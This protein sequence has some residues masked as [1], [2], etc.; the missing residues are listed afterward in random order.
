MGGNELLLLS[1]LCPKWAPSTKQTP[2]T[3]LRKLIFVWLRQQLRKQHSCFFFTN[4]QKN[5]EKKKLASEW[6]VSQKKDMQMGE[7]SSHNS[8]PMPS[9]RRSKTAASKAKPGFDEASVGDFFFLNSFQNLSSGLWSWNW[10]EPFGSFSNS[11]SCPCLQ[12]PALPRDFWLP[13]WLLQ[14]EVIVN[15]LVGFQG[16]WINFILKNKDWHFGLEIFA[17]LPIFFWLLFACLWLIRPVPLPS[18]NHF[19]MQSTNPLPQLP[20]FAPTSLYRSPTAIHTFASNILLISSPLRCQ[21]L[22]ALAVLL[23]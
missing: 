9:P 21:F 4:E 3:C 13:L 5:E 15:S 10:R 1:T 22:P 2:S 11:N 8:Y 16:K 18:D 19:H 20:T 12:T 17:P 14:P 6:K 7:H 23:E